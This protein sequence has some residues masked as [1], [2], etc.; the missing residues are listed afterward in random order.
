MLL[1]HYYYSQDD[2]E[3]A[4]ETVSPVRFNGF[5]KTP[6]ACT[7]TLGIPDD[8]NRQ[9]AFPVQEKGRV[10]ESKPAAVMLL[11]A[12]VQTPSNHLRELTS[13]SIQCPIQAI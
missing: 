6:D 13:Q 1:S 9:G 11:A 4:H 3:D 12:P 7:L 10:Q 5:H 2:G 8:S